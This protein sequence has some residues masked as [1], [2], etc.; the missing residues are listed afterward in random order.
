MIESIMTQV[1]D[2]HGDEQRLEIIYKDNILSFVLGGKA[3]FD[4]DCIENLFPVFRWALGMWTVK[5]RQSYHIKIH[6]DLVRELEER[7]S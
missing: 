6:K 4:G 7:R 1:I 5:A 3:L 2:V